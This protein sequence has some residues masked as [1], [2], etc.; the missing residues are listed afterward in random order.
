MLCG[1]GEFMGAWLAKG[2]M[3]FGDSRARDA[4]QSS[5]GRAFASDYVPT[6]TLLT[7]RY[8]RHEV[9]WIFKFHVSVNPA[10][11]CGSY[12]PNF[13]LELY[14]EGHGVGVLRLHGCGFWAKRHHTKVRVLKSFSNVQRLEHS[15]HAYVVLV[16]HED[17]S[18]WFDKQIGNC[19]SSLLYTSIGTSGPTDGTVV[20]W[21]ASS[22]F[23]TRTVEVAP[24]MYSVM[25]PPGL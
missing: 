20:C 17:Y 11:E 8:L 2:R 23:M 14:K 24:S 3:S 21:V 25:T 7:R 15:L 6:Y 1:H 16:L 13:T 9:K 12:F 19:H 10:Y 4:V 18:G 22:G 5:A